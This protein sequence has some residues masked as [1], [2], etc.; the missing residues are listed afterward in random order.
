MNSDDFKDTIDETNSYKDIN[1]LISR[2][3]LDMSHWINAEVAS[4]AKYKVFK[5]R[6]VESKQIPKELLSYKL[7]CPNNHHF[8]P[9][10]LGKRF[11]TSVL[12]TKDFQLIRQSSCFTKCSVCNELAVLPIPDVEYRQDLDIFGDEA[13]RQVDNKT[14]YVYSFVSFSGGDEDKNIFEKKF[15]DLKKLI[16]P[17]SDSSSRVLHMKDLLSGKKRVKNAALSR[18]HRNEVMDCI[19]KIIELIRSYNEK[20]ILNLYSSVGIAEG[21]NKK[22]PE[23]IKCKEEVYSASLI[24]VIQETTAHGLAPKFYFEKTGSDGW[25][26]NLFHGWRMTLVWP[27]ITKG[28]PVMSPKFVDPSFSLYLEIADILSFVV[29]RHLFCIGRRVEGKNKKAEICPSSLGLVRY[30]LL[31][32]KGDGAYHDSVGFPDRAMFKGTHWKKHI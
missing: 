9:N 22:G 11:P 23:G 32:S 16:A 10:W 12:I 6:K 24:R 29:A 18:L 7:K 1:D 3:D 30:I 8:K 27:W 19:S 2:L 15:L 5:E 13:F 17:L 21:I 4:Y 14:I 20:N 31:N 28:L 25:A 26:K